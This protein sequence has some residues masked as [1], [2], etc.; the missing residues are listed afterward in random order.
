MTLIMHQTLRFIPCLLIGSALLAFPSCKKDD[1]DTPE[2][3]TYSVPTT[4]NFDNVSY[5]G[6]TDRLNQLEE[7]TTYM[8]TGNTSGTVL[9]AQVLKDMYANSGDNGG[10]NFSFTSTKQLQS[11]TF[12]ADQQ[13]LLNFI[14]SIAMASTSATAG[15]NGV[16]GVVSSN[17]GSKN[18]LCNANGVEY[19]QLIEKGLMGMCFYYQIAEVYTRPDR[20]GDAVDNTTIEEGKGTD[21]EHHWDEAFGYF[22]VPVDFPTNTDVRFIG[23][24]CNSRDALLGTNAL[25]MDAFLKGRAAI[26]N[27]DGVNRDAAAE[28]VRTN[29]EKVFAATAIHYLNGA[30]AD[31]ADDALRNHQLSEAWAFI[32]GL[33]YNSDRLISTADL[34]DVLAFIGT[35]FYQTSISGIDQARIRLSEIYGLEEERDSL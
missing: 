14:D 11:K 7:M 25:V 26:S 5:S 30:K 15:S 24:Y 17:D 23:K 27:N 10:G 29:M 21:R 8:K 4:Y 18:Y 13:L 12:A 16:A 2:E 19:T 22:G 1:D 33:K 31:I 9:D 32:S 35:N 6:Q 3:C 34:D 28:E 20:I